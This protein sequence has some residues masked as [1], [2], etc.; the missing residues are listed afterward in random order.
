MPLLQRRQRET[1]GGLRV[2]IKPLAHDYGEYFKRYG[3]LVTIRARRRR[4]QAAGCTVAIHNH[5]F[6]SFPTGAPGSR[7]TIALL[8][9]DGTRSE[10]ARRTRLSQ[11]RIFAGSSPAPTGDFPVRGVYIQV[12]IRIADDERYFTFTRGEVPASFDRRRTLYL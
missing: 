11:Y 7:P 9:E 5:Y 4:R 12:A 6:G 1:I 8:S 10:N 3:C 2:V